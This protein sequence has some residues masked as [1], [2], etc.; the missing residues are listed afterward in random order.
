MLRVITENKLE[1]SCTTPIVF[2]LLPRLEPQQ[3]IQ[4]LHYE[5][6]GAERHEQVQ[7]GAGNRLIRALM[8]KGLSSVTIRFEGIECDRGSPL[9]SFV[10][11]EALP[12]EVLPYLAPSRYCESDEFNSQTRSIVEGKASGLEQVEA[13]CG[14]IAE[15]YDYCPGSSHR[16]LSAASVNQRREGVCRDFAHLSIAMC[17]SLSLPT[18]YVV[19]YLAGLIPQDQHA[20]IEVFLGGQWQA[21]DPTPGV[22][23]AERIR[24]AIGRDA[25]DVAMMDQ[26]GPLPLS[27]RMQISVE[28]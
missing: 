7:D 21:F 1:L 3:Q 26:F 12:T 11:I 9:G 20:W 24:V 22:E 19:G 5:V 14:M 10:P 28:V 8:Q 23:D 18:R 15:Q 25:A 17:R 2:R 4:D 27:S 16:L 6:V 13:I